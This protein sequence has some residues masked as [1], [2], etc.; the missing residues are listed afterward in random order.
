MN[1]KFF[2][3]VSIL[4]LLLFLEFIF[5]SYSFGKNSINQTSLNF[6]QSGK[7]QIKVLE[8]NTLSPIDNATICIIETRHYETTNKHGL[9]NIITVPILRNTNFDL[10]LTRNWG[11]L[12]ILVYK[13]G[14][15]DNISFYQSIIPNTTRMGL[16]IYLNPITST[17]DIS[18][19]IST[20]EP[21]ISY[22]QRLIKLY[23]KRI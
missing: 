23:K 17:D 8:S 19:T 5:L 1:K 16:I 6:A 4:S 7:I 15:A 18:P 20:E 10:S 9:S 12:T 14:Y 21:N 22:A 2:I 13:N 11:E 3:N